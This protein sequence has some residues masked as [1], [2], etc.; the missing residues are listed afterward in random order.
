LTIDRI[1]KNNLNKIMGKE[2]LRQGHARNR[3]RELT[4]PGKVPYGYRRHCHRYQLDRV[5]APMV[6][7]F[8]D[9]FLI[10]GSVRDA[11]RYLATKH[12]KKIS[13]STAER[14]LA[15]PVYRGDTAYG[16]GD[17]ISDT[18][19]AIISRAEAAQIDRLRHRSSQLPAR[20]ASAPRS[21][22]GLVS[23]QRCG[24]AFR[25]TS[26]GSKYAYLR[27][28]KCPSDPRCSLT[29]YDRVLE[30]T[31][32]KLCTELPLAVSKTNFTALEEIR[33]KTIQAIA[34]KQAETTEANS[35]IDIYR[36]KTEISALQQQLATFSPVNITNLSQAVSIPQFWWDL[37][38]TE[39]RFY[40][41]EFLREITIVAMDSDLNLE[42]KFNFM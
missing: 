17:I 8:F 30:M 14:W 33:N 6:K 24:M 10:Y 36:I 18:H 21:L 38:E 1:E 16:N 12:G 40:F 34:A 9:R 5:A 27:P 4:P 35:A 28:N 26:A 20:T 29:A 13:T 3:I 22:A 11:V 15:H 32:D 23:C 39:R 19:P 41:R 42:L 7:D 31:I 2:S 25:V 37:T